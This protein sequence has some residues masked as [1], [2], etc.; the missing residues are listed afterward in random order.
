MSVT[1]VLRI[2]QAGVA[3]VDP[4]VTTDR[5][6]TLGIRGARFEAL[7]RRDAAGAFATS[8]A[9]E[10]SVEADARTWTFRVRSG[11]RFHDGDR[12]T[13]GDVV[14]SIE[15]VR[16][17][18]EAG[19]LGTTGVIQGYLAGAEARALDDATVRIVTA[20]PLADLLD[21]LVD[22][23]IV[24]T[25]M[26]GTGR[27]ALEN[28]EDDAVTMTAFRGYWGGEA[29]PERIRWQGIADADARVDALLA[30]EVDLIADV[31][32]RRAAEIAER[33]DLT[34]R[35]QGSPTCVAFLCNCFS[36]PCAD[37]R[38]RRALNMGLDVAA[39]VAGVAAGDGEPLN[40]PLTPLH[41]AYDPETP[42]FGHDPAAARA[43]LAEAGFGDGLDLTVDVP[44]TLPDEAPGLARVMAAM[45]AEIGVRTTVREHADREGYAL[46]VRAK[47]IGDAACFDSSPL[48]S[49]RVMREKLHSG[50]AGPW[51]QGYANPAVDGL[52]DRAA[53]TPEVG[54]RQAIY[55]AAYRLIREDA[56]WIFLYRPTYRWAG[57]VGAG[58]WD[59][60][61][62][63]MI[64]VGG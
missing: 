64:E 21:L 17:W 20:F 37:A 6:A 44:L 58:S 10:W 38:V 42:I 18:T 60:G 15:R 59:V 8:L 57:R 43:L 23:P 51:W 4:H 34:M 14:R 27:Y 52:L 62:G 19:E 61:V 11:V 48:S 24:S 26:A 41:L 31:P 49:Y 16:D 54:A 2:G 55:R 25:R 13:A 50:V 33:G 12:L 7:A 32:T 56:P 28:A 35:E 53:R 5:R 9:T 36:G 30:G 40:G 1:G 39:L 45:W 3:A 29:G 22:L 46:M 47:E 63:G